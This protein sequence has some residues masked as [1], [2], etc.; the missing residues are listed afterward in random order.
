MTEVTFYQET[1]IEE[2]Q[3]KF[4]VI[5]A[6]CENKWVFCRHRD[7]K[8]WEIP[9]GHREAGEDIR[10]TAR[11]ELWEETGALEAE[12]RPVSVYGVTRDGET[13]YGMLFFAVISRREALSGE[14]ETGELLFSDVMPKDLTYPEIQ[15]ELYRKVQAWMNLDTNGEELWDVYDADRKVTGR[16][17]RRKDPA[18]EGEYYLSVQVWLLNSQGEFLITKRSPNKGYPNIWE[19]TGGAAQAG[20]DSL[21]AAL[22]EV[23]EETGLNLDPKNGK[24]IHS[25]RGKNGFLD[26]WLFRQDF[27]LKD[28]VLLEGE[29]CDAR[30]ASGEELRSMKEEGLFVSGGYLEELLE[31]IKNEIS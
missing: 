4:A 14:F 2:T 30:Y 21:K 19:T 29:T 27:D 1:E 5:A 23:Q 24:C 12:I 11:R 28:V 3:L 22:R 18:R 13:S 6:R 16:L 17:H 31:H 10:E 26:I 15:P 20:D 7:R 9:G 25:T 8:T